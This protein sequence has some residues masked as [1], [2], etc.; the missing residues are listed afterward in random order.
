[1]KKRLNSSVCLFFS[2]FIREYGFVRKMIIFPPFSVAFTPSSQHRP[3][4]PSQPAIRRFII[5][6]WNCNS[7]TMNK[8]RIILQLHKRKIFLKILGIAARL[9][10]IYYTQRPNQ[11]QIYH[12]FFILMPCLF[13]WLLKSFESSSFRVSCDAMAVRFTSE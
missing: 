13:A 9:K 7:E 3:G 6:L 5:H 4:P 10:E 12:N 11:S 1:M 8:Q 2:S